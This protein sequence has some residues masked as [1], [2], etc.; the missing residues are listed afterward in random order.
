MSSCR[1]E[2]HRVS[3]PWRVGL[4]W[5]C[6]IAS[7]AMMSDVCQISARYL[8]TLARDAKCSFDGVD[9]WHDSPFRCK[10]YLKTLGQ[11]PEKTKR[12][13]PSREALSRLF[14]TAIDRIIDP[15]F[16]IEIS[17]R[18][19]IPLHRSSS[20][21][22]TERHP[23]PESL[24]IADVTSPIGRQLDERMSRGGRVEWQS[25]PSCPSLH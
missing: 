24:E 8:F 15:S 23:L 20:H 9:K 1:Y 17:L 7:K 6:C 10:T 19:F 3:F 21:K 4:A 5:R 2:I 16:D 18:G 14:R 11:R 25:D 12:V 13:R 22:L